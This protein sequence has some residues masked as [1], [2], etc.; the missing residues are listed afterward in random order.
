M[1]AGVY[2][3][4]DTDNLFPY[5]KCNKGNLVY[6]FVVRADYPNR[7]HITGGKFETRIAAN[8]IYSGLVFRNCPSLWFGI[9]YAFFFFFV[10]LILN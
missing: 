5:D 2:K 3:F 9:Q 4:S 1:T 10:C 7:V 8:A 6:P